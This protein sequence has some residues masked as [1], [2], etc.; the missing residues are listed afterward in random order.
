MSPYVMDFNDTLPVAR[1]EEVS[2][3]IRDFYVGPGGHFSKETFDKF[4]QV[5]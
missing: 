2:N 1:L 5:C 4:T 3:E